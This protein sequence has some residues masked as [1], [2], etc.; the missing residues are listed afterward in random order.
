MNIVDL[1]YGDLID[2]I[3]RIKKDTKESIN[4]FIS[5]ALEDICISIG[6][7]GIK[8]HSSYTDGD[9]AKCVTWGD[10]AHEAS[11]LASDCV[12]VEDIMKIKSG[13]LSLIECVD[14][15]IV[16]ANIRDGKLK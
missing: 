5:D 4:F 3:E 7:E 2:S 14:E 1:E 9:L 12:D 11:E 13:L 15:Q 8:V 6:E 10:V 16:L